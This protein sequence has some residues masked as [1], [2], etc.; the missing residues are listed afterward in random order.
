MKHTDKA[1]FLSFLSHFFQTVVRWKRD[2]YQRLW[3][4]S[5]WS[6]WNYTL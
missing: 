2:I 5:A 3:R 1:I 4:R 6:S